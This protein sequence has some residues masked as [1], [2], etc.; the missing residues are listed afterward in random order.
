MKKYYLLFII[1][2]TSTLFAQNKVRFDSLVNSGVHQIYNLQFEEAGKTFDLVKKEYPGHP[3]G[4]FYEAMIYWWQIMIDFDNEEYDEP[5]IDKLTDVIDLCDD[6]LDDD[7]SNIDALFFKGGALGFRGRLYVVRESWFNAAM[8]GKDALPIVHKAYEVDPDN[9][10]VQLGFGIYN[11]YAAAIPDKYPMV[12]P[13]L[14]FFP[15]GDKEK[16]LKQLMTAAKDGKYAKYEARFTLASIYLM[17]E[18]NSGEVIHYSKMLHDDFPDNPLFERYYGRG[19]VMRSDYNT[20]EQIFTDIIAKCDS[21]KRGYTGW[22]KREALYYIGMKY[23]NNKEYENARP[24]FEKCLK[25]SRSM[26]EDRD[27]E[28]GFYVNSVLYMGNIEDKAGNREKAIKLYEEVLD[29]REFKDSHEKA[30][31]Y[32]E[33]PYNIITTK[34][35]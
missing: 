3:A 21:N 26:E 19:Y 27:E 5:F 31:N 34:N 7:P 17:F 1:L 18:K 16:G 35:G 28:T 22:I 6:I 32:L 12:E 9:K 20:A 33:T 2:I 25:L 4:M 14:I 29:L 13:L 8:D 15:E 11:Y 30:E 10:D 24:Y 23:F